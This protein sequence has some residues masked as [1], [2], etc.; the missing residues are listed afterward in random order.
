MSSRNEPFYAGSIFYNYKGTF[1]IV[2]LAMCDANYCFTCTN[3]VA[4]GRISNGGVNSCL[5]AEKLDRDTLHLSPPEPLSSGRKPTPYLIVANIA[6]APK[7]NIMT[8][9]S[10]VNSSCEQIFNYRLSSVQS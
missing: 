3:I 6:F 10:T 2:L 5:L 9:Y 8:P 7:P 4:Q 1:D